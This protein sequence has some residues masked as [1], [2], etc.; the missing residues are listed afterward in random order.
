MQ[1]VQRQLTL[2]QPAFEKGEQSGRVGVLAPVNILTHIPQSFGNRV[3]IFGT[4]E[5]GFF[6]MV[7]QTLHTVREL[8]RGCGNG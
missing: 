3:E 1:F 4:V 7:E 8:K 5:A 2:F 6:E